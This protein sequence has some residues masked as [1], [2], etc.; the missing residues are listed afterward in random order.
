M[1]FT[2]PGVSQDR[3]DG[4]MDGWMSGSDL[5]SS[6]PTGCAQGDA[7]WQSWPEKPQCWASGPVALLEEVIERI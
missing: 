2:V 4:E 1:S 3:D 6:C 7:T 5:R